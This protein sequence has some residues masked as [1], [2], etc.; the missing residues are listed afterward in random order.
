[1]NVEN[2][3]KITRAVERLQDLVQHWQRYLILG[4]GLIIA[5]A[6]AIYYS[7]SATLLSVATLGFLVLLGAALEAVQSFRMQKWSGFFLHAVLALVYGIVGFLMITKPIE[8]A[9]SLTLLLGFALIFAGA[10][11]SIY[12]LTHVHPLGAWLLLSGLVTAVLGV[13]IVAQLPYSGLWVIG[14]LVGIDMIMRGA[15]WLALSLKAH[16][17]KA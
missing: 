12:S 15:T 6:I 13:M 4:V 2:H 17:Y 5:G 1:M 7:V 8:S 16:H 10:F 9:Q 3:P 14:T 11:K